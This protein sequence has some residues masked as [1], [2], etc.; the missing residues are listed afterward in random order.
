MRCKALGNGWIEDPATVQAMIAVARE[1]MTT[2]GLVVSIKFFV[3]V[4]CGTLMKMTPAWSPGSCPPAFFIKFRKLS[5]LTR[6]QIVKGGDYD[7]EIT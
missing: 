6:P 4:R 2:T 5:G 7:F 3:S 1:L